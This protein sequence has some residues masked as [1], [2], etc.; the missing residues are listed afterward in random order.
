MDESCEVLSSLSNGKVA[1]S[2]SSPKDPPWFEQ[3][4]SSIYAVKKTKE[5]VEFRSSASFIVLSA[6]LRRWH[7]KGRSIQRGR[8]YPRRECV[9]W[10]VGSI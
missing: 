3:Q 2:S 10:C 1:S 4:K 9:G 8:Q 7:R 6:F 5:E